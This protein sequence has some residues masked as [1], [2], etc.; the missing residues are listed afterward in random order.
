LGWSHF[1]G[2]IPDG[3]SGWRASMQGKGGG[4]PP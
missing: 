2:N 1:T 3:F 4:V